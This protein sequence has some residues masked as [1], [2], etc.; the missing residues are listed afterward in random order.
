M[1]RSL[2]GQL[3]AMRLDFAARTGADLL[4]GHVLFGWVVRHATWV[5]NRYQPHRGAEGSTSYEAAK[6]TRYLSKV[7]PFGELVMA[8]IPIDPSGLRKKL[9]VQWVK[10]V[11]VGR[12]ERSDAH[13]V[14]LKE[15]IVTCKTVRRLPLEH[16]HGT[17]ETFAKLHGNVGDPCLSQARLLKILPNVRAELA[18]G[19]EPADIAPGADIGTESV[20]GA[21]VIAEA[22]P[23][24]V[25]T[26]AA[27]AMRIEE[28]DIENGAEEDLGDAMATG[29]AASARRPAEDQ[30]ATRRV[31][32]RMA[33]AAINKGAEPGDEQGEEFDYLMASGYKQRSAESV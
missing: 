6:G 17:A 3:R 7:I 11:R 5:M 4:P 33:V 29:A 2:Q 31:R 10:G 30:E 16:R 14:L 28:M 24:V 8:R 12:M 26:Q 32:Q 23:M 25:D 22:E 1:H 13:I 20:E 21:D 18:E 9:N 27:E 19:D 15:G